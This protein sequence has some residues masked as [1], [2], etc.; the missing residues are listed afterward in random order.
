M[1]CAVAR[2]CHLCDVHIALWVGRD[3]AVAVGV[4]ER[5]DAWVCCTMHGNF[6]TFATGTMTSLVGTD[7]KE[8]SWSA[9]STES[10]K[11]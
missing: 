3:V 6:T 9:N 2:L 8:L 5:D 10:E 4:T 1:G 11:A 7:S